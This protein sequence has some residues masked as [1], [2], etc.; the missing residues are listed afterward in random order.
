MEWTVHGERSV[1][2]SPWVSLS[3]VDVEVP[4][5]PR[6][7]HHVVRSAAPAVGAVVT[8]PDRG[9]LMLWRHRFMTGSWGWE[10]PAG[11]VDEGES[12]AQ[13]CAREVLEET[14]WRPGPLTRLTAFHPQSGRSDQVFE[15]FAADG[16]T[17]VGEPT[18]RSE[19][20]RVEW[21]PRERVAP[22]IA[23]GEVHDGMSLVGLLWWLASP[24]SL[25]LAQR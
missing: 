13:A 4:G 23:S 24:G 22:L 9:V 20:S 2:S 5:G 3:L 14:G 1:Y 7:E 16:A 10:L 17:H 25:G 6:F 8:D 21:V 12:G 15:L 18:D 19:A 11:A